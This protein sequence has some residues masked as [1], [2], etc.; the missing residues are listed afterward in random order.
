[1]VLV[2]VQTLILL[3]KEFV[4]SDVGKEQLLAQLGPLFLQSLVWSFEDRLQ[5]LRSFLVL[6]LL[7]EDLHDIINY[8]GLLL[9]LRL[10]LGDDVVTLGQS[11]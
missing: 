9:I 10:D 7:S 8:G 2:Q 3:F 5:E 6:V 11:A 4:L 1:M